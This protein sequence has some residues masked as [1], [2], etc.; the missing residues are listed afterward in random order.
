[1][2]NELRGLGVGDVVTTMTTMT[3]TTKVI[4]MMMMTTTTAMMVMAISWCIYWCEVGC[5]KS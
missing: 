4:L 5:L 2:D 1:M 3:T